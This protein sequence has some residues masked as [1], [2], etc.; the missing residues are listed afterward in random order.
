M[1]KEL[2]CICCPRGCHLQVDESNNYRVIG[3]SCQRGEEYGKNE[4]IAPTRIVTSTVT[5]T[6]GVYPRCPVKT[7][8]PIPKDKI[9]AVMEVL[10]SLRLTAP[11]TSGQ[12]IV[13]DVAGTGVAIV[14]TRNVASAAQE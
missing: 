4:C 10:N 2:I 9:F 8:Q 14:T 6:D 13:S 1:M 5:V 7:A 12:V 3:N 11:V